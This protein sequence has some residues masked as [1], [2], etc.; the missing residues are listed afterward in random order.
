MTSS[1]NELSKTLAANKT[2]YTHSNNMVDSAINFNSELT[3][4][5]MKKTQQEPNH[6]NGNSIKNRPL[7]TPPNNKFIGEN[8]SNYPSSSYV[9]MAAPKVINGQVR[10]DEVS[11]EISAFL[12]S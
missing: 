11:L 3:R 6:V 7:P 9:H 1:N 10:Y 8:S 4:R 12:E 2:S 5:I